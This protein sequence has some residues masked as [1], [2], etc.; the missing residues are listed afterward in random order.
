MV[1]I[2]SD[3]IRAPA[4]TT[5]SCGT[6]SQRRRSGAGA[7]A[8]AGAGAGGVVRAGGRLSRLVGV[9]AKRWLP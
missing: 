2:T 6:E 4:A 9:R 7:G 3:S 5:F 1:A 8:D